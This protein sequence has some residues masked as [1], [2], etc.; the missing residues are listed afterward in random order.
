[1]QKEQKHGY[2]KDIVQTQHIIH[3]E[4]TLP[5]P[6][7]S[8]R[9][10]ALYSLERLKIN[11]CT[12]VRKYTNKSDTGNT[13]PLTYKRK[14]FEHSSLCETVEFP[15]GQSM[16]IANAQSTCPLSKPPLSF[17]HWSSHFTN[18]AGVA[19]VVAFAKLES[20]HSLGH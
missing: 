6:F 4:Y 5:M 19:P 18:V 11:T 17:P 8:I 13:L 12:F 9:I 16:V 10:N 7:S 20:Y 3:L 14:I 15:E 1:M 2:K